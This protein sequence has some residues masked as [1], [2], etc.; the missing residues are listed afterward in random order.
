MAVAQLVLQVLD[1]HRYSSSQVQEQHYRRCLHV[2]VEA[3]PYDAR[4]NIGK[5]DPE[6]TCCHLKREQ[7]EVLVRV[8]NDQQL[9]G[10]NKGALSPEDSSDEVV[11]SVNPLMRG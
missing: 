8:F 6:F 9:E 3:V 2:G 11:A 10:L 7:S 5:C 1:A 4:D